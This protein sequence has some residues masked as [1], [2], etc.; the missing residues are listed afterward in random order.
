MGHT[1][2]PSGSWMRMKKSKIST[3]YRWEHPLPNPL[4]TTIVEV[5]AEPTNRTVLYR[6]SLISWVLPA[7]LARQAAM[8]DTTRGIKPIQ[9]QV[10]A[11]SAFPETQMMIFF[12]MK[13]NRLHMR[14]PVLDLNLVRRLVAAPQPVMRNGHRMLIGLSSMI[15]FFLSFTS[16]R[17]MSLLSVPS[18]VAENTL[19][20]YKICNHSSY[21]TYPLG[22]IALSTIYLHGMPKLLIWLVFSSLRE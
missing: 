2:V 8:A 12:S 9:D 3:A 11:V 19:S 16:Y 18:C 7:G 6:A 1:K 22:T 20:D 5:L 4:I 10:R 21:R 15:N 17:C 13:K 14:R